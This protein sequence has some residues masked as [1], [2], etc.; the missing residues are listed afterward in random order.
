VKHWTRSGHK[1]GRQLVLQK[2]LFSPRGSQ[3]QK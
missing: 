1:F 3:W 2:P